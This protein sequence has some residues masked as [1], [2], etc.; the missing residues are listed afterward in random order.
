MK[1]FHFAPACLLILLVSSFTGTPEKE[2]PFTIK[3][4]LTGLADGK[5]A[6]LVTVKE[7]DAANAKAKYNDTLVVAAFKNGVAEFSGSVNENGK[8]FAIEVEGLK[9]R[10]QLLISKKENVSIT[11]NTEEWP[12]VKTAGSAGTTQMNDYRAFQLNAIKTLKFEEVDKSIM[13]YFQSHKDNLYAPFVLLLHDGMT[14]QEKSAAFEKMSS[15]A[16]SSYYGHK[17]AT[18]IKNNA[19]QQPVRSGLEIPHF[20]LL[21]SDGD[22]MSIKEIA[23]KSKLTL[24][25]CWGSFCGPCI[26]EFPFLKEV[27]AKYKS[28]GFNILG[29]SQEKGLGALNNFTTKQDLPWEQGLDCIDNVMYKIFK[30]TSVPAYALID[31]DGKMVAFMAHNAGASPSFGPDIYHDELVKALEELLP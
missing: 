25:D 29:I 11:G 16:K 9:Q 27:Y 3:L 23:K 31:Q 12:V 2:D 6:Y 30:L 5:K 15:A 21:M 20:R 4:Q 7:A 10:V 22:T 26:A 1:R 14:T 8:R 19:M 13:K 17:L 18:A 28:K 24:I